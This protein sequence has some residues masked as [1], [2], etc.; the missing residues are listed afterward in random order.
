ME[1]RILLDST[2]TMTTHPRVM[3]GDGFPVIGVPAAG[4]SARVG[5]VAVAMPTTLSTA[6]VTDRTARTTTTNAAASEGATQLSLAASLAMDAGDQWVIALSGGRKIVVTGAG[7]SAS[8]STLLLREPLPLDVASGS[9]VTCTTIIYT[10]TALQTAMRGRGLAIF[11]ASI[12]SRAYQWHEPFRIVRRMF[13]YTLTPTLLTQHWPFLR[14]MRDRQDVDFEELIRTAFDSRIRP[15]L[16]ARDIDEDDIVNAYALEPI[17][18]LA[19]ALQVIMP[20]Q[21]IDS[22]VRESM[23]RR[24]AAD[25]ETTFARNDWWE[26]TQEETPAIA[27]TAARPAVGMRLTR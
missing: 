20:N 22:V 12:D 13:N 11:Q 8:S 7:V 5:T 18:A 21:T 2:D 4:A 24:W 9:T 26:A 10:F 6:Q 23:D 3:R 19:C 17:H 15:L 14:P 25:V 1:Q 27:Q 16:A